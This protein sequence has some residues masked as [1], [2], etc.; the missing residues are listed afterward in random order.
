MD[1]KMLL[2]K[3]GS[4]V[5]TAAAAL[6]VVLAVLLVGV[7]LAGLQVFNVLSGSMEPA[8]PT[9]SILY[10]KSVDPAELEVGD[11]ITFM[12][13]ETAVVTHRI[14]AI[15]QD[16]QDPDVLWLRT[17]G[18]ANDSEDASAVHCRNV[19]GTPVFSIPYLGYVSEYI[20]NPPGI[21]IAVGAGAALLVLAFWPGG[22]KKAKD[23]A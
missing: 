16:E 4:V 9:G 6:A 12:A 2:R 18:D 14:V 22:K 20:Q 15:E 23:P 7:R 1:F 13:S 10:V 19:I 8:Y 3:I 21:Y 5:S 11:P 17:K